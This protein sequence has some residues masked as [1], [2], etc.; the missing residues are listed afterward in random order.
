MR[1]LRATRAI[2]ALAALTLISASPA[3]HAEPPTFQPGPT[4]GD[5][6]NVVNTADP[7]TG[8]VTIVRVGARAGAVSCPGN[9][10]F[11]LLQT[12]AAV[13][14][15]SRSVT[16]RYAETLTDPYTWITASVRTPGGD[17]LGGAKQRGPIADAG[18]INVGFSLPVDG[19]GNPTVSSVV[20]FVGLEVASACPNVDGG[21]V[22]FTDVTVGP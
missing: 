19:V 2:V 14:A 5:E 10:G 22:R 13:S 18:A 21:T 3:L 8:R 12:P 7:A 20:V 1:R 6:Y 11:A 4:G 16:I 15:A 9:G 17:L